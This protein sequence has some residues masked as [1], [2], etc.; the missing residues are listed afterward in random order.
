MSA[1]FGDTL[2]DLSAASIWQQEKFSAVKKSCEKF[3][4]IQ[5][6]NFVKFS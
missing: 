3:N 1:A 4:H 5:Y 2:Q 6:L